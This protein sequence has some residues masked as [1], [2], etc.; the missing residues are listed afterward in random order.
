MSLD[1]GGCWRSGSS[2]TLGD[3]CSRPLHLS[4]GTASELADLARLGS[5]IEAMPESRQRTVLRLPVSGGW[6]EAAWCRGRLYFSL[7]EADLPRLRSLAAPGSSGV[8][9]RD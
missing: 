5:S 3:L 1:T 2:S 9:V 8:R 7:L 4:C 6:G